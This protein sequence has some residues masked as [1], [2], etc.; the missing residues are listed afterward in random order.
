MTAPRYIN[1]VIVCDGC[2][3][4]RV[5][6]D[7]GSGARSLLEPLTLPPPGRWH[8]SFETV[9]LNAGHWIWTAEPP[10]GAS[11]IR[12]PASVVDELRTATEADPG[13]AEAAAPQPVAEI[14]RPGQRTLKVGQM[15]RAQPKMRKGTWSVEAVIRELHDDGTVVVA[16]GV[17]V[18][19]V[20]PEWVEVRN[21]VTGRAA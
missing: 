9:G 5:T 17:K 20:T 4:I 8:L 7:D 2:P 21:N 15:V 14:R 13:P 6:V 12:I 16:D 19:R 18:Y 11:R 10:T 1:H 3:S